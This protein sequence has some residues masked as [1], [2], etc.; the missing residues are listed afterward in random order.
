MCCRFA[1]AALCAFIVGLSLACGG[2][3]LAKVHYVTDLAW[4]AATLSRLCLANWKISAHIPA[5][6]NT[7]MGH[8]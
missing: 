2:F 1:V 7:G 5:I 3:A 4:A 8:D 6:T